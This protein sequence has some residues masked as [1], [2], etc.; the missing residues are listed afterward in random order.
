MGLHYW[1]MK[2]KPKRYQN[3]DCLHFITFSCYQAEVARLHSGAGFVRAPTRASVSVAGIYLR[4]VPTLAQ[5][6]REG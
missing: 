1:G 3:Q 4:G 2:P 6:T 5:T